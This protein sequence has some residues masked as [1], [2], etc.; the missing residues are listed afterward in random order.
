MNMSMHRLFAAGVVLA[1]TVPSA[2]ANHSVWHTYMQEASKAYS[3]GR[4]Q[5]A[6]KEL[7]KARSEAEKYGE[8]DKELRLAITLNELGLVYLE[9]DKPAEAEKLFKRALAMRENVQGANHIDVAAQLDNLAA[10]CDAKGTCGEAKTY[11][12]RALEIR[13]KS[14]GPD[15]PAVAT[16][17]NNLAALCDTEGQCD[18]AEALLKEA[19][20]ID[21]KKVGSDSAAVAA[22]LTN[23]AGLYVKQGKY[24]QAEPLAKRALA[25]RQKTAKAND[26]A[27]ADARK[28]YETVKSKLGQ[29]QKL[30]AGK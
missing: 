16:T 1:L 7:A 26:P 27:L 11:C 6:E 21:E 22:D 20:A 17:L 3:E 2:Y 18:H 8:H 28:N 19:L 5:Q 24:V 10:A 25:I 9:E 15:S 4:Y 13:K 12:E 29:G 23:L 14:L 30:E